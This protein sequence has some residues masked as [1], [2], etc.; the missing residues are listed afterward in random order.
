MKTTDILITVV[1]AGVMLFAARNLVIGFRSGRIGFLGGTQND[2]R[3]RPRH[4]WMGIAFEAA[5]LLIFGAM[6]ARQLANGT[7][8][9]VWM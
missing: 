4:Y 5:M 8:R 6:L 9:L 1:L 3:E 2:R 7:D